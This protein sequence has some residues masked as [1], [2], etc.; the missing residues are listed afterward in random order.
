MTVREAI[1]TLPDRNINIYFAG[2]EKYSEAF[3][4][5]DIEDCNVYKLVDHKVYADIVI[6]VKIQ[7]ISKS[8]F[9][10]RLKLIIDDLTQLRTFMVIEDK[11][12][13]MQYLSA[14]ELLRGVIK[15]NDT[16]TD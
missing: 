1:I 9:C 11:I 8:I 6:D 3:K 12:S 15:R 2:G 14:E 13:R 16:T 10:N 5:L 4:F 7:D